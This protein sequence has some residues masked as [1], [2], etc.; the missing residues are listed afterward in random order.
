MDAAGDSFFTGL[1]GVRSGFRGSD[2]AQVLFALNGVAGD[3]CSVFGLDFP[4]EL[5]QR[6]AEGAELLQR[7]LGV[8]IEGTF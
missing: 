8:G 3:L 6:H 2:M 4:L 1:A 7:Q 5:F